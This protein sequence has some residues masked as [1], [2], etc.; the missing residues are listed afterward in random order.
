MHLQNGCYGVSPKVSADGTI[1]F[2]SMTSENGHWSNGPSYGRVFIFQ[3]DANGNSWS[4]IGTIYGTDPGVGFAASSKISVDGT[5]IIIAAADDDSNGG[6]SGEMRVFQY[7][8]GTS[9]SKF[10]SFMIGEAAGDKFGQGTVDI[11]ADGKT[12]AAAS[13]NSDL[14]SGNTGVSDCRQIRVFRFQ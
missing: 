7:D 3:W 4:S 14:C 10:G 11:S 2:F 9:W 8:D 12:F 13:P 5:K 1:L 6:D